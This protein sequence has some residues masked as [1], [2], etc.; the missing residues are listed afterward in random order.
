MTTRQNIY[1]IGIGG[2]AMAGAAVMARQLGFHVSGSDANVY[3][4]TSDTLKNERINYHE[5]YDAAHLELLPTPDLI[6]LGNAISRGNAELEEALNRRLPIVSLPQFF[7]DHI[8]RA[9]QSLV[10]SGTHGKTTTTSLVA[11]ALRHNGVDTGFMIG[12]ICENFP[13]G[14]DVGTADMFVIEGD[15]YDT[16]IF[17]KRSKFLSYRPTRVLLN[18][19]EF[20][21]AD[22]FADLAAVEQT[23]ANLVKIIPANG[24]LVANADN[25]SCQKLMRNAF[26]RVITFGESNAADYRLLAYE[27]GEKSRIRFLKH[28]K[29]E[30]LVSPLYGKHNALNTLAALALVENELP[31]TRQMQSALDTFLGVRRRLQ[32]RH[33]NQHST[34]LE[35]FAHHPTAIRANLETLRALY[36]QRRLVVLIEPRSNTMVRNIFQ[37][38]LAEALALADVAIIDKIYRAEKYGDSERLDLKVLASDLS[39]QNTETAFLPETN[40]AAFVVERLQPNDVVCFMTNG[41]FGGLIAETVD[42]LK[43]L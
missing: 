24:L 30:I 6:V 14:S 32:I 15:E 22:I 31:E 29:E 39:A 1:F 26:A 25:P 12:G 20:D 4:P 28:G 3:P 10:V 13:R 5:G 9:R 41:S 19:I 16:S 37:R 2:T 7:A 18:N 11:H 42:R 8:I 33:E 23:F 35:D 27:T 34:V 21:H 43:T 40:R 17:D 38:E 36:P